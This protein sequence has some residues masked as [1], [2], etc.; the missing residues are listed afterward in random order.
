TRHTGGA[1]GTRRAGSTGIALLRQQAPIGRAAGGRVAQVAAAQADVA[2]AVEA[3]RVIDVVGSGIAPRVH[4]DQAL[5]TRIAGGAGRSCRTGGAGGT[6]GS[7]IARGTGRSGV[8][9]GA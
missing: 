8:A 5:W 1:G 6:G 2:R 7:R 9:R 4:P 3:H